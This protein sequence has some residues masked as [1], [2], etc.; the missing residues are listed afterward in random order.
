M[1]PEE[2][3]AEAI[4][5]SR[6]AVSNPAHRPFAAFIVKDGEIV[7]KGLNDTPSSHDP[8]AHGEVLAIRDAT[9]RLSTQDLSGCEIY[10]TCE[11]CSLC[12]AA[13]WWAG[14]D[15]MYYAATLKD[16]AEIGIGVS[17]L[18]EEIA[19][20]VNARKMK[21]EQI[22]GDESRAVLKEWAKSPGFLEF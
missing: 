7:G 21:A 6:Q 13:I 12:V 8:T 1:S 3:M 9:K 4:A 10:T 14:L 5:I 2:L 16:C 11:P 22:L 19:K 17:G 15:K 20:P 18:V